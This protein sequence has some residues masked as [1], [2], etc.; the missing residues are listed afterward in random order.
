MKV[1]LIAYITKEI[2]T[3]STTCDDECYPELVKKLYNIIGSRVTLS[4]G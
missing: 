4:L 3:T 2:T 1:A